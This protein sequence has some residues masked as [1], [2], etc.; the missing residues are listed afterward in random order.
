[1]S[2][3]YDG[4]TSIYLIPTMNLPLLEQNLRQIA[5]HCCYLNEGC[6]SGNNAC[7]ANTVKPSPAKSTVT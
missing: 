2:E 3:G 6:V 7:S 1:M 5:D 4:D